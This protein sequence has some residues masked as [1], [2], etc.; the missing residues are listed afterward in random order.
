MLKYRQLRK[1]YACR[2]SATVFEG[3]TVDEDVFRE[4]TALIVRRMT[5][6][7]VRIR[8]DVEVT[9]FSSEGIDAIKKAL[10]EGES[11]S[12]EAIPL[13]I[14]LVAPPLYVLLTTTTEKQ[15]GLDLLKESLE[16][17][18]SKIRSEGGE[19]RIL[20]EVSSPFCS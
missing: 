4:L 14:K 1:F 12:T 9:C 7:A 11:I 17:I 19:M 8:A 10:I 3:M 15:Q 16:K 20:K 2:D 18:G 6:Q 13:K 5:P